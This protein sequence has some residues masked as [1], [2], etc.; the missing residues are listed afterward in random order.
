MPRHATAKDAFFQ[1]WTAKH[2][3]LVAQGGVILCTSCEKNVVATYCPEPGPPGS[4]RTSAR[5][6]HSGHLQLRIVRSINKCKY[7]LGETKLRKTKATPDQL[8]LDAATHSR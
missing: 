7:S 3:E 1:K 5:L 2:S 4:A 6:L 8:G